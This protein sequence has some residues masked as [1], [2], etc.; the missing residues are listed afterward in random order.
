VDLYE[1]REAYSYGLSARDTREVRK[2]I[3]QNFDEIVEEWQ[4]FRSQQNG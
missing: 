2:I 1:I 3:L 4:S